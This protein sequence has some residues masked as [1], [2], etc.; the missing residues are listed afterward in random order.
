MFVTRKMYLYSTLQQQ[1][2]SKEHVQQT[3]HASSNGLQVVAVGE[4]RFW[5]NVVAI[6]VPF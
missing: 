3:R 1:G 4:K 5:L 6:D 2:I